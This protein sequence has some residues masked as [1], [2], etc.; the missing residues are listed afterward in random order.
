MTPYAQDWWGETLVRV[1]GGSYEVREPASMPGTRMPVL[2]GGKLAPDGWLS[3][4]VGYGGLYQHTEP[5]FDLDLVDVAITEVERARRQPCLRMVLPPNPHEDRDFTGSSRRTC[6][7]FHTMIKTLPL[8]AG[9]L[10]A[11]YGGNIRTQ[12]RRCAEQRHLRVD[13]TSAGDTADAVELLWRTQAAVGSTYNSPETLVDT[14]VSNRNEH[15]LGIGVWSGSA[16]CSIGCFLVDSPEACYYLN[17]WDRGVTGVSVNVAMLHHAFTVLVGRGV[18]TVDLG[19][20]HTAAIE[21]SKMQWC[22]VR[23][24]FRKILAGSPVAHRVQ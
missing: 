23:R 20:S 2:A 12:L 4:A 16:L 10:Y 5:V 8:S 21:R 3:G 14:F 17:G 24:P 11:S 18:R 9:D 15:L 1:F 22:A 13:L 6:D 19:Y 7:T